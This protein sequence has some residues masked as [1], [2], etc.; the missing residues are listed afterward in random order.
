MMARRCSEVWTTSGRMPASF[1][2]APPSTASVS[3]FSVR[4]TSTQP[5]NRF[6]AFQSLSPWRSSTSV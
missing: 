1:S 6:F 4:A 5:V 2:S 3:P